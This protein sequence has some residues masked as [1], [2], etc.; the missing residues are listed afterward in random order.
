MKV[1]LSVAFIVNQRTNNP[2]ILDSGASDHM[3]GDANNVLEF[4]TSP[5]HHT[6]KIA[7]GTSSK[8]EG[9]CLVN[10]N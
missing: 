2:L 6:V 8:V 9:S 10:I 3:T 4:H 1:N 5:E 7:N